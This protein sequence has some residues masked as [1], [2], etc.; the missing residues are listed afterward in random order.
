MQDVSTLVVAFTG[1][2]TAIG[3]LVSAVAALV[4]CMRQQREINQERQAL[5]LH[6]KVC[7][8]PDKISK[9]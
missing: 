7:H 5:Q 6:E 9:V 4:W 1:L 3:G 2:V 8:P